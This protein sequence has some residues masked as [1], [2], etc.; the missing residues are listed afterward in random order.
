MARTFADES[1]MPKHIFVN[2]NGDAKHEA[3]IAAMVEKGY[4]IFSIAPNARAA[5]D[6]IALLVLMQRGR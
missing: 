2:G 6:S 1:K 4:E 5:I 3:E